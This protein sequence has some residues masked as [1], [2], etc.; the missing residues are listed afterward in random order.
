MIGLM[1]RVN[2]PDGGGIDRD[3]P[4]PAPTPPLQDLEDP[5]SRPHEMRAS[6]RIPSRAQVRVVGKGRRV[7]LAVAINISLGGI[8]LHATPP[9]PVGST[10]EVVIL[11]GTGTGGTVRAEGTVVRSS[12]AGSAV[13]FAAPLAANVYSALAQSGEEG[14]L[15]R[16][17]RTYGDYFRVARSR[18]L[19]GCEQI[20][21]VT[22]TQFRA[23]FAT[24]FTASIPLAVL[25]VWIYRA[26]IPPA[27]N[28][29]KIAAAFAYAAVWFL[30]LQPTLD[31]LA[32]RAIRARTALASP[33]E[34]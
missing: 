6:E 24:T 13:K 11:A 14:M 26:S 17:T 25:P 7:I 30:L 21:G 19:H 29:V 23:I 15:A 27:P 18:R 4:T 28:G 31:I 1:S 16:I 33:P 22:K 12:E 20:L 5:M 9:L 3:D 32:I 2:L 34:A 8:L 10:C